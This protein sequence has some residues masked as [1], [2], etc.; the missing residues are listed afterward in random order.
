MKEIKNVIGSQKTV[1]TV[2]VG[3]TTV[4]VRTNIRPYTEVFSEDSVFT[5]WMYDETQYSIEEYFAL[6]G[7]KIFM[8]EGKVGGLEEQIKQLKET[9]R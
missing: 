2:E 7:E 3:K 4:Y 8:L 5:G 1:P 6:C 9:E